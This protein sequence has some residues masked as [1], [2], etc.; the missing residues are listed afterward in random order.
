[1][2]EFVLATHNQKKLAELRTI[3]SRTLSAGALGHDVEF[4]VLSADDVDAPDVP[5]TGTTFEE[6]A[7]IKA[8]AL[9][10]RGYISVADDSGLEVDALDGAPGVY[11]ARYSGG[12]D[13][14]NN[15][16]LLRELADVPPEKR[17]A[18]FVSAIC[19]IL[20]DGR[21]LLCRGECPGVIL[22]APRGEGGFGYYPLFLYEPLGKTFSELTPEEKN[23]IS[24]RGAALEAFA[25]RLTDVLSDRALS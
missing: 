9:A 18:R 19:C 4:S 10:G 17:T 24:H 7:R 25:K 8:A 14:E 2:L 21:E 20:P 22:D 12:G 23:Q 11:S 16:K 1:M 13:G 15:Q 3:L 5:E 6:N